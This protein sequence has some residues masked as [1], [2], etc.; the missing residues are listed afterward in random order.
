MSL[1]K[2]SVHVRLP[3]ELHEQLKIMADFNNKEISEEGRGCCAVESSL[4]SMNSR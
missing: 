1:E 4:P 2:M 3:P